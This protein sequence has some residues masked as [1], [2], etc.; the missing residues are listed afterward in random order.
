MST[1][2]SFTEA[3]LYNVH[4]SQITLPHIFK[5]AS[6]SSNIGW[7]RNISRDFRHNALTSASVICTV[8][9]GLHPLTANNSFRLQK[10][11]SPGGYNFPY[12]LQSLPK[13]QKP[14]NPQNLLRLISK[15]QSVNSKICAKHCVFYMISQRFEKF[16][17]EDIKAVSHRS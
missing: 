16:G 8:F 10:Y 9:P 15:I 5:G 3:C 2:Y 4:V 11:R 12:R 17:P 6:N 14:W 1:V 7:L 13:K